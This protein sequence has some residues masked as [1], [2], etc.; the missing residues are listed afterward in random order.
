MQHMVVDILSKYAFVLKHRWYVMLYEENW[1]TFLRYIT[2]RK[3]GT[4]VFV[5]NNLKKLFVSYF[6]THLRHRCTASHWRGPSV[7]H[8]QQKMYYPNF[9]DWDEFLGTWREI[10]L[11]KT[12]SICVSCWGMSKTNPIFEYIQKGTYSTYGSVISCEILKF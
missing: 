3:T 12:C 6:V 1:I 2:W 8:I 4:S 7:A 9:F 11:H 5:Y 10:T